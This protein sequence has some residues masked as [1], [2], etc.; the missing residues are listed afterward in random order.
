MEPEP[1]YEVEAN[2]NEKEYG[3]GSEEG[4]EPEDEYDSDDSE[5]CT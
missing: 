5:N 3:A 2:G 1:R 4:N